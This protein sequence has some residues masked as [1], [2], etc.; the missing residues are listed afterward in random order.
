MQPANSG[1]ANH[2]EPM[3]TTS[4]EVKIDAQDKAD[5]PAASSQPVVKP[6]IEGSQQRRYPS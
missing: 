6:S 2:Q 1:E 5:G 3:G 4:S